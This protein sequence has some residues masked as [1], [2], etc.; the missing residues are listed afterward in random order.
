MSSLKKSRREFSGGKAEESLGERPQCKVSSLNML[1]A[2]SWFSD[3]R[4][5]LGKFRKEAN[6]RPALF[7]SPLGF[8]PFPRT[9]KAVKGLI[10]I[11]ELSDGTKDEEDASLLLYTADKASN[12][13]QIQPTSVWAVSR[14]GC[15]LIAFFHESQESEYIERKG[16]SRDRGER[17]LHNIGFIFFCIIWG[18]G[19]D[20][21][22]RTRR[23]G[24]SATQKQLSLYIRC[25]LLINNIS[26]LKAV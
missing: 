20:N 25:Q 8:W 19:I 11:D 10:L 2:R 16:Y 12:R 17:Q 18:R 23:D 21:N 15:G 13:E 26:W 4:T 1:P 5:L 14:A 9:R 6:L 22:K 7:F 3:V 24:F